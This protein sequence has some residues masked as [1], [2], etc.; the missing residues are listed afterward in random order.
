[1]C[2]IKKRILLILKFLINTYLST[3]IL[4]TY[5]RDGSVEAFNKLYCYNV[6]VI[7]L[8]A[9]VGDVVELTLKHENLLTDNVSVVSNFLKV[10]VDDNGLSTIEGFKGEKL[11]H[12]FNKNEH[13]YIETHTNV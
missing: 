3:Y 11:I 5:F 8:S 9:G 12:V 6:P 4:V 10:T 1:V 7:V 2:K 13:T